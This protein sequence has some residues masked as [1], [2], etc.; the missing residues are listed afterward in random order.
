[1]DTTTNI[2]IPGILPEV[3]KPTWLEKTIKPGSAI[4]TKKPNTKAAPIASHSLLDFTRDLPVRF[5]SGA[6]PIS[7]P[8]KNRV[9]PI[10]INIVPIVNLINNF[11]SKGHIVVKCSNNTKIKIGK[12]E[13]KTSLNLV[14]ITFKRLLSFKINFYPL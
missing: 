1:M 10:N 2:N 8:I 6:I 5:P 3:T 7:T 12:T 14:N 11:A 4:D 13:N 9:S